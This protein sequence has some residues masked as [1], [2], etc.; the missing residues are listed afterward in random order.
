MQRIKHTTFTGAM[1]AIAIVGFLLRA[2]S[3]ADLRFDAAAHA[4]GVG[5]AVWIALST[6]LSIRR[7]GRTLLAIVL[8]SLIATEFTD[9]GASINGAKRWLYIHGV[10]IQPSEFAKPAIVVAMAYTSDTSGR[11]SPSTWIVLS[12]ACIV[13]TA[14]QPSVGSALV[15]ATIV[16][17]GSTASPSRWVSLAAVSGSCL[18]V[19]AAF[20][21][22]HVAR[23]LEAFA[24]APMQPFSG[25]YQ[26]RQSMDAF[27]RGG[28]LGAGDE[29][30]A[31]EVLPSALHD[32]ALASACERFGAVP[33]AALL[34]LTMA[35]VWLLIS[36]TSRDEEYY[37][38]LRVLALLAI[39]V[40]ML[41]NALSV[42]G[43]IPVVGVPFPFLSSG[44]SSILSTWMLIGLL[45]QTR[46]S[47]NG[48]LKA[49]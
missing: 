7:A 23:R 38:R 6:D 9:A 48:R 14:A 28:L 37:V 49:Q 24:A 12:L 29:S 17:A 39:L 8:L 20:R 33:I 5:T 25:G 32:F 18:T 13:F 31:V 16:V 2:Y 21:F 43:M 11:L 45:E 42:S 10:S 26:I 3:N 46:C 41:M 40:P 30:I 36:H 27:A 15:L 35:G 44:G 34:A 4:L 47:R 1:I 19:V 22:G